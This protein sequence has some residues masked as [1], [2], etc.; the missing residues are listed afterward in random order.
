MMAGLMWNWSFPINKS[1]WTSSYVIFTA[2]MACVSLG[3]CI[4]LVDVHDVRWWTRPFVIYGTNPIVAFVGSGV[5]A[6]TIYSLIHV[7][8]GGKSVSIETAMYEGG[9]ATW[10]DPRNASLAFAVC[11]VLFWL[12]VL[13][14]LYRRK[15]FLKV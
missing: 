6:R 2:G 4:W 12:A 10:L 11:N 8:W 5:L 15:I 7:N 14:V 13:T 3:V 1:L 9:F